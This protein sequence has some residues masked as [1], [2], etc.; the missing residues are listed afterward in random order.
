MPKS[1]PQPGRSRAALLAFLFH[2]PGLYLFTP[3]L[4]NSMQGRTNA[5]ALLLTFI[6]MG[7]GALLSW[8]FVFVAWL[9][10]HFS[11]SA[12]LAR[13]VWLGRCTQAVAK[14]PT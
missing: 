14:S 9:I 10:G 6:A 13:L 5:I 3:Y 11:W 4:M 12:Y 7:L 2:A 8:H 1:S